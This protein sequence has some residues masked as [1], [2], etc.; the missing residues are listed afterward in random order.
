MGA[1]YERVTMTVEATKRASSSREA[2]CS[3][4]SSKQSQQ[5]AAECWKRPQTGQIPSH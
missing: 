5:T 1:G 3:H 4:P 2:L